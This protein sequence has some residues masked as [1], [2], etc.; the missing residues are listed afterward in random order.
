MMLVMSMY[1]TDDLKPLY[2]TQTQAAIFDDS[3]S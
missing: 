2:A 1:V 3:Q